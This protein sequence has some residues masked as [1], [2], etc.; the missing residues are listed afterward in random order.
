MSAAMS[1]ATIIANSKRFKCYLLLLWIGWTSQPTVLR[2][3]RSMK[4]TGK[5]CKC[6][7]ASPRRDLPENCR[8]T[9]L[10]KT[11]R[12]SIQK[13]NKRN[14]GS[15]TP[16]SK[17]LADHLNHSSLNQNYAATKAI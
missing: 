10:L 16:A 6:L 17:H 4:E 15:N 11:R 13:I 8:Q 9:D 1:A 12:A 7:A 3:V 5:A 2:S 14:H